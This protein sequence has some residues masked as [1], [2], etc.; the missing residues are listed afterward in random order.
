MENT[1]M[2]PRVTSHASNNPP[3]A[4]RKK[5]ILKDPAGNQHPLI[6]QNSL[7][8]VAWT[9]SEKTYKQKEFQ[10]GLQNLSPTPDAQAHLSITKWLGTNELA[11]AVD[12]KCVP[13]DLI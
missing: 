11:G 6:Q 8:L 3:F 2:V 4:P 13:L 5:Y 9:I 7:K 10:K 12:G 1:V